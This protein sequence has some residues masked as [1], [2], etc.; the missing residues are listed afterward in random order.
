MQLPG[1]ERAGGRESHDEQTPGRWQ[2][3]IASELV[4]SVTDRN[5]PDALLVQPRHGPAIA[6]G[7][8]LLCSGTR[9]LTIADGVLAVQKQRQKRGKGSAGASQRDEPLLHACSPSLAA[10]VRSSKSRPSSNTVPTAVSGIGS[11]ENLM[12]SDIRAN[13]PSRRRS[14]SSGNRA[15]RVSSRTVR[16]RD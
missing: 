6:I 15:R 8:S 13:S 10:E 12:R 2:I 11:F 1:L 5:S 4:E 9:H 3:G 16:P 7:A 14:A